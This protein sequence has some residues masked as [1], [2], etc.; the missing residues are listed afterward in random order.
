MEVLQTSALPLGDGAGRNS[1]LCGKS[2]AASM[3][4]YN[5]GVK[6]SSASIVLFAATER[7]CASGSAGYRDTRAAGTELATKRQR[8]EG[9]QSGCRGPRRSNKWSGKRDSNPRLRPWQGRTL[10]LSY[11]RPRLLD[12]LTRQAAAAVQKC[13]SYHDFRGPIKNE[14]N[15]ERAQ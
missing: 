11:S 1:E 3:C 5:N 14:P 15:Q 6:K 2:P 7:T 13:L 8:S 12:S 4:G 10:P 9:R